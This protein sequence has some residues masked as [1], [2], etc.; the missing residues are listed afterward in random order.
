MAFLLA[1]YLQ[2]CTIITL[3]SA[4]YKYIFLIGYEL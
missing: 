1:Q 4:T 3:A 2:V